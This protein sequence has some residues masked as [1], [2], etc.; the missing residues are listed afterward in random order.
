LYPQAS[1]HYG[2]EVWVWIAHFLHF[3]LFF[4][5]GYGPYWMCTRRWLKGTPLSVRCVFGA[6]GANALLI[7]LLYPSLMVIYEMAYRETYGD[8]ME[9]EEIMPPDGPNFMAGLI[10]FGWIP[11]LIGFWRG[12]RDAP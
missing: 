11:T 9:S 4:L 3:F 1:V 12:V 6:V 8:R 10:L 5:L 2:E 7:F